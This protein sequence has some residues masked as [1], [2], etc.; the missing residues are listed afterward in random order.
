MRPIIVSSGLSIS[1]PKAPVLS[2]SRKGPTKKVGSSLMPT[3]ATPRG[4]F[5][6]W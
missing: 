6:S 2:T 5:T 4:S 1:S 3:T